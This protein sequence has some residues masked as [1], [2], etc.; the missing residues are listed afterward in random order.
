[1]IVL[2][3]NTLQIPGGIAVSVL[4]AQNK[5]AQLGA[6]LPT[7]RMAAQVKKLRHRKTQIVIS[8]ADELLGAFIGIRRGPR[9]MNEFPPPRHEG[10][11]LHSDAALLSVGGDAGMG[12]ARQRRLDTL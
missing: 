3:D 8:H 12:L 7:G 4:H 10:D 5:G 11:V 9:N 2:F 1:M 6:E